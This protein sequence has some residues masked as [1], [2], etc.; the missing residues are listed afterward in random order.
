[1]IMLRKLTDFIVEKRNYILV[2][3][4]ILT[5]VA[6]FLSTKVKINYDMMEYLPEDSD[7]RRGLDIMTEEF[8]EEKTS[9]LTVTMANLSDEEKQTLKDEFSALEGV[10][11]LL[12]DNTEEY[13]R[14]NYTKYVLV[15]NDEADSET[16]RGVYDAVRTKLEEGE[17]EF[18]TSGEVDE[19]NREVLA[20]WILAIAIGCALVILIIMSESYIEPVLFMVAI[21]MAVVLNKGSNVIFPSVSHITDSITA[22]LQLALSMD[23]SIMLMERFRQEKVKQPNKVLAMKAALGNAFVAIA[24]SSVTTVVGLLALVFMS[25]TIGRDMGLVLAKGVVFSLLAIF[26]CLP[27]LILLFDKVITKTHK[28]CPTIRLG[29]LG[30]LAYAGRFVA[31]GVFVLA[32]VGSYLFKGNLGITYT[33]AGGDELG[34]VFPQDN[35]MALVY[36][37]QDEAEAAERCREVAKWDKSGKVVCYGNTIGEKLTVE[38]LNPRLQEL[39]AG[40]APDLN[41]EVDGDL[42]R[43]LYYYYYN[44]GQTGEMTATEF[45]DFVQNDVYHNEK[46]AGR[47]DDGMRAQIEQLKNFTDQSRFQAIHSRDELARIFE[48]N[49]EQVDDLLVYYNTY[50]LTTRLSLADFVSFANNYVVPNAKYGQNFDAATR[51]KLAEVGR[52]T[53]RTELLT[54]RGAVTMANFLGLDTASVESL[55]NYRVSLEVGNTRMSLIQFGQMLLALARNPEYA[56]QVSP[57]LQQKLELALGMIDPA[58]TTVYSYEEMTQL[59]GQMGLALDAELVKNV[60]IIYTVQNTKIEMTPYEFV[61][62]LL[63]QRN[64]AVL[65]Q[66]L[67]VEAWR[68]LETLWVVMTSVVENRSYAPA[69]MVSLAGG[70]V[71]SMKLLYSL[72][73]I[74]YL[75]KNVRLSTYNFAQFLVNDVMRNARY[76]ANFGAGEQYKL[77]V[78]VELMDGVLSGRQYTAKEWMEVLQTFSTDIKQNLIEILYFYHGS[79]YHYVDTW[80]L[81]IEEIANYLNDTILQD[82]RF[83]ELVNDEARAAAEMAREMVMTAKAQLVGENYSRIVL[84]TKLEAESEETF[85]F[86]ADLKSKFSEGLSTFY[87]A[88]NSPMAYEMSQS[89]GGEMDMITV[90]TMIFIFV[91][92]A[93]TFRSIIVPAILVLLIQCAVY[94]TMGVLSVS[95]TSLYFIALLIVQ[96]ILMGATIDYAV[97]Y[98]SYY[99]EARRERSVKEAIIWAYNRSIQAIMTSSLIL[100]IV[101]LIVGSFTMAVVSKITTAISQGTTM[102]VVLILLLLPAVLAACDRLIVKKKSA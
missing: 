35:Q 30:K 49:T 95:G 63:M 62:F 48:V 80:M 13:N 20:P 17:Y 93:I 98:T 57:E 102:A 37:N 50:N 71:E 59:L 79:I 9:R 91:V 22:I 32:F 27:G 1:M 42:A 96:S 52:Y 68:Q 60:Y 76:A 2:L 23:Y 82:G 70:D 81:T 7:T 28:K 46:F 83:G 69:E 77:R 19:R 5:G 58:D 54:K 25:F 97:L 65:S 15:V 75:G 3:M 78:I 92:V 88:G 94:L 16:A 53:N 21:L 67:P 47:I 55:Y 6:G 11:E 12:Y 84:N 36:Q 66:A 85:G 51:A 89:F 4:I 26:T 86:I 64:D 29:K 45:V 14:E 74:K 99:M 38:G 44:Q 43:I 34:S 87:V 33:E 18:A 24:S 100:I 40:M 101:T 8:G 73:E 56:G 31:V 72:Y 39:S 61:G 10:E 41:L 90:V